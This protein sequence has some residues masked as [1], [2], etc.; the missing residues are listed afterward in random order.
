[1]AQLMLV[2]PRK[3]KTARKS[4]AKKSAAKRTTRRRYARNP[5]GLA[6]A[7][8][9]RKRRKYR[10]NP[11]AMKGLMAPIMPAAIAAGG[12][13]G[14]DL[15]W[16]MIGS[17]LPAALSTGPVRHVAKAA[18]ALALGALAGM[19][20]KKETANNLAIGAL[21]VVMHGAMRETMQ[22][23]LPNV[24]LGEYESEMDGLAMYT[25]DGMNGMGEYVEGLSYSGAGVSF[26]S[27]MSGMGSMGQT[28]PFIL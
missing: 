10:R 14:L 24:A 4:P 3:R 21:T 13:I 28:S 25:G 26:D 11:I 22:K 20:L 18:G 17:K 12:A 8:P 23:M 7:N 19:V 9:I 15:A 6:A 2:N 1:M 16:G 27:E 5:I